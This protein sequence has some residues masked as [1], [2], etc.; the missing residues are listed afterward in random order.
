M[1]AFIKSLIWLAG[2]L[3]IAYFVLAFF[4]YELNRD[5]FSY[6]KEEC[7]ARLKECSANVIHEGIDNAECNFVCVNPKL[8]IKKK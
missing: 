3:V 7:Q 1:F 4:G 6:S 8:I 5:F 2:M